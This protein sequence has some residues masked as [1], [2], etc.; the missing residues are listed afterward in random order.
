MGR[1]KKKQEEIITDD[2]ITD[3]SDSPEILSGEE[4]I[5]VD[6]ISDSP[7]ILSGEEMITVDQIDNN[8]IILEVDK[9]STPRETRNIQIVDQEA[10]ANKLN[11]IKGK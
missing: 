9:M 7:E 6:D 8:T 5:T 10:K 2:K 11:K 4:M 1:P 3:I